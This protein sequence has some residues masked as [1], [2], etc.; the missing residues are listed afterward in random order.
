MANVMINTDTLDFHV[1]VINDYSLKIKKV[2]KDISEEMSNALKY[3]DCESGKMLMKKFNIY[4]E[5]FNIIY[6]NL[7]TY[8]KDLRTIK[9]KYVHEQNILSNMFIEK[10]KEEK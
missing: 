1:Y 8:K 7:L 10:S 3:Y 9:L 5:N 6:R 4:K 2:L